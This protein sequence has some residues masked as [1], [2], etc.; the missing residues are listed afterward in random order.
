MYRPIYFNDQAALDAVEIQNEAIERM[1]PPE[2]LAVQS[3]STQRFPQF[4][5]SGRH[6]TVQFSGSMDDRVRCWAACWLWHT[7]PL[8]S[9]S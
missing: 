4:F 1:L 8:G 9:L 7:S 3:P 2:F 6:A 5:L